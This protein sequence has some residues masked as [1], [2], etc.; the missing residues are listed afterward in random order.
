MA[1]CP[2]LEAY[3]LDISNYA[4]QNSRP[5]SKGRLA[6][7]NASSLPFADGQFDCAI[8]IDVV[9]NLERAETLLAL[10]ELQRVSSG[11]AF[12]RVDSYRSEEERE[13][14]LHWVLTAKYHDTPE[15]WHQLFEEAGYTGDY[16]WTIIS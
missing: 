8:S 4:L 14:F 9:H 5:Q 11:R 3:G 7:G 1:V 2:G 13:A 12:V 6:L 15:G 16:Y 10:K